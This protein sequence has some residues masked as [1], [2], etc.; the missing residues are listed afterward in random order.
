MV[1]ER[2]GAP[3][4]VIVAAVV[5]GV[6]AFIALLIA[7]CAAYV[8]FATNS[9]L[10]PR[11]PSVRMVAGGVDALIIA[12]VILS[13]AT[14]IGLFRLKVWSRYSMSVLGLLDLL[15]FGIMTVGVLV[16]RAKSGMAAMSIPN[17]PG[18]TLG[19]IMAGLACLYGVL[20]LIGVWWM[21]YFNTERI[22]LVFAEPCA[23]EP[24]V[25]NDASATNNKS[26]LGLS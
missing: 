13:A 16:A 10:I 14:I 1:R 9:A 4:G 26:F 15:V 8:M 2:A 25:I 5:L 7:A 3:A 11:I 17:N 24:L 12:L 23:E 6:M 21:I 22:R 20:A 18:L 19:E